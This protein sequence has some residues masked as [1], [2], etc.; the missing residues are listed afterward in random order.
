VALQ[1]AACITGD[2]VE[3][4]LVKGGDHRLSQPKDLA[5]LRLT[6]EQLLEASPP[7]G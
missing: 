1:L 4:Q 7:R 3:V 5:R 6:V 2:D